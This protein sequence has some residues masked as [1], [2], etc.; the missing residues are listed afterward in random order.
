MQN[1]AVLKIEELIR[2]DQ[3]LEYEYQ[4]AQRQRDLKVDMIDKKYSNK[5][6]KILRKQ[7]F[8]K[9]QMAQ[10]QEYAKKQLGGK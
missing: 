2:E 3:R 1:N 5:I 9:M 4:K 7:E 8:V 10:V 6:D